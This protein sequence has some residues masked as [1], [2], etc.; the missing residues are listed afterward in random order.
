MISSWFLT[1]LDLYSLIITEEEPSSWSS[2]PWR[3]DRANR[4]LS[5]SDANW[6]SYTWAPCTH[7]FSPSPPR[8]TSLQFLGWQRACREKGPERRWEGTGKNCTPSPPPKKL[9]TQCAVSL[10][11]L[12][13][14]QRHLEGRQRPLYVSWFRKVCNESYHYPHVH[15]GAYSDG[16]GGEE[17]SPT[18]GDVGQWEVTFVHRLGGLERRKVRASDVF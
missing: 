8:L 4:G 14:P 3:E 16:E 12:F 6:I 1:L 5:Q 13:A 2:L 7:L 17:Q 9:S 10:D 18:G 15:T 11:W